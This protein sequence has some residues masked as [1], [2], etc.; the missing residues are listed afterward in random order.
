MAGYYLNEAP[1]YASVSRNDDDYIGL[2]LSSI[3]Y[4]FAFTFF[5]MPYEIV[6][7][8]VAGI[9]VIVYYATGFPNSISFIICPL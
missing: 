1:F 7:G 9:A 5:L 8:G 4:A 3:L 2:T 6:T